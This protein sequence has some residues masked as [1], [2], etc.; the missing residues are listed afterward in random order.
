MFVYHLNDEVMTIALAPGSPGRRCTR[1]LLVAAIACKFTL[2]I[3][4]IEGTH[5][6]EID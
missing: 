4:I 6:T 2:I 3:I 5:G 1:I